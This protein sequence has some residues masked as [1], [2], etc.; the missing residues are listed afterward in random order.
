MR[1]RTATNKKSPR[2]HR[3]SPLLGS[4][5]RVSAP[6]R[7]VEVLQKG[8]RLFILK[9]YPGLETPGAELMTVSCVVRGGTAEFEMRF[10][11]RFPM[12]FR[13]KKQ[14]DPERVAFAREQIER[15]GGTD[16]LNQCFSDLFPSLGA[17]EGQSST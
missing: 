14:T 9:I 3:Y 6:P 8:D 10:D 1:R 2:S 4:D 5:P 15:A 12:S 11:E 17:L 13:F 16:R 7:H